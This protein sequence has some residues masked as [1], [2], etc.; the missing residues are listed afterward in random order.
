[1]S[2]G[3]ECAFVEVEPGRWYYALENG[4]GDQHSDSWLDR[5]D[6]YGPFATFEEAHSH[7]GDNHSNPGGYWIGGH[8]TFTM[9]PRWQRLIDAAP[10][11]MSALGG[12][13]GRW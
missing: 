4:F 3:L 11:A 6:A 12:S 9:S 8:D 10:E 7:L 5:A 2:T 13:F 1:M